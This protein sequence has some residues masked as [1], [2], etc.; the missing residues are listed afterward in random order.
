[1]RNIPDTGF[2]VARVH[3]RIRNLPEIWLEQPFETEYRDG[4]VTASRSNITIARK[5]LK[6]RH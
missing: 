5:V 1:M 4:H 3:S 2:V 6:E